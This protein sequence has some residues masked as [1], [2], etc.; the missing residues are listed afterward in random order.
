MPNDKYGFPVVRGTNSD[1]ARSR[2]ARLDNQQM[3]QIAR[4]ASQLVQERGL[5]DGTL[6]DEAGRVCALGALYIAAT[7]VHWLRPHPHVE[8]TIRKCFV[9][10]LPRGTYS[11]PAWNDDPKTTAADVA[12]VYLQV[13]DDLEIAEDDA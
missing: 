2:R 3:A 8:D 13:A 4:D 9:G 12:K 6:K 7:G 5:A 1:Y 11:I 10:K